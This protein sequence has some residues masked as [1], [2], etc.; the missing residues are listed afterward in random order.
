ML[1]ST[2]SSPPFLPGAS[3]PRAISKD[4]NPVTTP[5]LQMGLREEVGLTKLAE[6]V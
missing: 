2:W 3:A 6:W 4:A 5:T 1:L